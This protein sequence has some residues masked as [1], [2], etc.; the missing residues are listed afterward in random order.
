MNDR[1]SNTD[2]GNVNFIPPPATAGGK[3]DAASAATAAGRPSEP[4]DERNPE[5]AHSMIKLISAPGHQGVMVRG[6]ASKTSGVLTRLLAIV[7]LASLGGSVVLFGRAVY[8]A[9]SDGWVAPL[10]LSPDSRDVIDLRMQD[11]K[12]KNTR[13]RLESELSGIQ[14]ELEAIELGLE[15][16]STLSG[17]YTGAVSWSTQS[18]GNQVSALHQQREI[19]ESRIQ[20]LLGTRADE[21][22]TLKRA[23]GHLETGL[24]TRAEWQ[25]AQVAD[26]KAKVA[27]SE[28]ELELTRVAA[29]I[30]EAQR[31]QSALAKSTRSPEGPAARSGQAA[32]P[33]VM[34]FDDVQVNIQLQIARLEAEKRT[35]LARER[36]ARSEIASMDQ[37][38]GELDETPLFLAMQQKMDIAFVPYNHLKHIVPGDEVYNCSWLIFNCRVVGTVDRIFPGEVITED[39]WRSLARGQYVKLE[40]QDPN[41]LTENALRVRPN[42]R[43]DET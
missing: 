25:R 38:R 5:T 7:A 20:I 39:P 21:E 17:G 33:D 23:Q 40:M 27:I 22:E 8:T 4:D 19:L 9:V 29:A 36:V 26:Q 31:E 2:L 11:A 28:A 41:A 24:I 14:A 37:L 1:L 18:R 30:A 13:A 12:E 10:Q 35:A 6:A 16:L 34:R 3:P 15:R 32:S 43:L 42:R